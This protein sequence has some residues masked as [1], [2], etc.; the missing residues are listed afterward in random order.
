MNGQPRPIPGHLGQQLPTAEQ[1][2]ANINGLQ[3][4][5]NIVNDRLKCLND[6]LAV[7]DGDQNADAVNLLGSPL[8]GGLASLVSSFAQ[9]YSVESQ[10][11]AQQMGVLKHLE[12]QIK[13]NIVVPSFGIPRQ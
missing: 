9:E 1:I 5:I 8:V 4:R 12:S 13:S 11:L 3:M 7:L 10:L 6:L 2:T